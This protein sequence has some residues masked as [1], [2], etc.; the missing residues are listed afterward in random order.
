MQMR[1]APVPMPGSNECSRAREWVSLRLD[2]QLSDLESVF[3]EAHLARC[4]D[5]LDSA[6][7]VTGLTRALRAAPLEEASFGFRLPARSGVRV[8]VLR[9]AS[10]AAA[11]A[12]VGLSWVVSVELQAERTPS[13]ARLASEVVGLKEQ[14][15]EQLDSAGWS[16]KTAVP[17][18]LAAA[19][20]LTVDAGF[21][22]RR[23]AAPLTRRLPR[24]GA[25][26]GR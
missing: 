16:A 9:A 5:C 23:P 20:Q 26:Q 1:D 22:V 7:S 3:L 2:S 14:Q 25:T 18:G 19:E 15:L 13:N 17:R 11:A 10:A 12:V 8:H 21:D 6:V 24:S 4:P